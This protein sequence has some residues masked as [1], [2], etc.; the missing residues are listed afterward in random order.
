MTPRKT[1]HK[2]PPTTAGAGAGDKSDSAPRGG[3]TAKPAK[4]PRKR[5]PR[6][7]L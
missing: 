2:L 4:P 7:V 5:R 3:A 6:F 1:P